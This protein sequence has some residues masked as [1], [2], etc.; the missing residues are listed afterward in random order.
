ML[1]SV[2]YTD[3]TDDTT[4]TALAIVTC[5]TMNIQP[6]R[7]TW[8]RN[9]E[10]LVI[11][12]NDYDTLQVL[13]NHK[14]SV[15]N[16]RLIIMNVLELLDKPTYTCYISSQNSNVT[17]TRSTTIDINLT[18]IFCYFS[19]RMFSETGL[20]FSESGSSNNSTT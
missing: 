3:L 19:L 7:V 5:Q 2:G 11:N 8:L 6:H 4:T 16:I 17:L 14:G 1:S 10:P 13:H 15:Y 9:G 18:G 20:I 12:G